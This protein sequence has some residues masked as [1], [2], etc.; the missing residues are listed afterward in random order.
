LDLVGTDP[1]NPTEWYMRMTVVDVA[2]SNHFAFPGLQD[3]LRRIRWEFQ[4]NFLIARRAYE[5][6]AGSDGKGADPSK[7]DGVIVAI[8]P[9]QSHFDV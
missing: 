6:V 5:L 8:Y 9:I 7:N 3:E 4:E 1:K 2:R